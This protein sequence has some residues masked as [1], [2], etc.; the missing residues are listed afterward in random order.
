MCLGS[1]PDKHTHT[2]GARCFCP[3]LLPSCCVVN[4]SRTVSPDESCTVASNGRRSSTMGK[5]KEKNTSEKHGHGAPPPGTFC[6]TCRCH[7]HSGTSR[8]S[9]DSNA[10]NRLI[11]LQDILHRLARP[12]PF[13][14]PSVW[15]ES[16]T[17]DTTVNYAE[18]SSSE[19]KSQISKKEIPVLPFLA[20]G[21]L[22]SPNN[23]E[24]RFQ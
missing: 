24:L 13:G 23:D 10:A 15:A 2:R 21:R 14:T 7:S 17:A 4:S 19:E 9:R 16:R 8:M 20:S 22:P 6:N 1:T 12:N 11:A 5:K 18:R 3:D